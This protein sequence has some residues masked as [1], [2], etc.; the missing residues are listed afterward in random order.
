MIDF[1]QG[2]LFEFNNCYIAQPL[3]LRYCDLYQIGELGLENGGTIYEHTQVCHEISYIVSGEGVFYSE[4]TAIPVSQGDI[5]VVS[6]GKSHKIVSNS[7]KQLR[8]IYLGFDF[9]TDYSNHKIED[10][11]QFYSAAPFATA[12]DFGEVRF[13]LDMLINELYTETEY[14]K[15]VIESFINQVLIYIYRL[16]SSCKP[17]YYIPAE[18]KNLIGQTVYGII[19]Y[20][21]SNIF[22]I[23][24]VKNI[25]QNL[26]YSESYISHLFKDKVGITIQEYIRSKK[27][28]ASIELLKTQKYSITEISQNLNYDTPQAFS[29]IFKKHTGYSPTEY[30]NLLINKQ[31]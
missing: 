21:D 17:Q 15:I 4:G 22:D 14:S 9:H 30:R 23:T 12:H 29:K 27:I 10:I 13:L 2:K 31:I 20:I 11:A 19:K 1:D 25:A 6:K 28:D 24:S 26:S 7:P 8:F 3:E 5:H 16:F 18:N